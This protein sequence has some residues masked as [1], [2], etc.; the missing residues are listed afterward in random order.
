MWWNSVSIIDSLKQKLG[1]SNVDILKLK[2]ELSGIMILIG[3]SV[4][5]LRTELWLSIIGGIV[6]LL[7]LHFFIDAKIAE[8]EAKK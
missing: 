1:M 5:A 7:G 4:I 8:A 2:I 6:F 3:V